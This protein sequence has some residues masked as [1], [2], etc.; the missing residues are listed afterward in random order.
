MNVKKILIFL[1]VL[2]ILLSASVEIVQ[3]FE[4]C[5]TANEYDVPTDEYACIWLS[6]D[7]GEYTLFPCPGSN[8]ICYLKFGLCTRNLC[9]FTPC[10]DLSEEPICRANCAWST[11]DWITFGCG[12]QILSVWNEWDM[13]DRRNAAMGCNVLTCYCSE[14]ICEGIARREIDVD[15]C[16]D[17]PCQ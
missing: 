13:N 3:A 14:D 2:L 16:D 17:S 10:T 15:D 6:D 4:C 1:T 5:V 7:D 9:C 12:V 11:G 8:R